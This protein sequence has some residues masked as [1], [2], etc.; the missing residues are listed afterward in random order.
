M[1]DARA[2]C[3]VCSMLVSRKTRFSSTFRQ[4][5]HYFCC[6]GCKAAFDNSPFRYIHV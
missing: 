2:V 1:D 6:K 5:R 4:R 3:P